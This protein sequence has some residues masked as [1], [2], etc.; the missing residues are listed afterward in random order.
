MYIVH[1]A[2][3]IHSANVTSA[4]SLGSIRTIFRTARPCPPPVHPEFTSFLFAAQP[5]NP[6]FQS[7]VQKAGD[8]GQC[9][10]DAKP[11]LTGRLWNRV[12]AAPVAAA[13]RAREPCTGLHGA[14]AAFR[15]AAR[16]SAGRARRRLRLP[17]TEA[18]RMRSAASP[19]PCPLRGRARPAPP[20]LRSP[21]PPAAPAPRSRVL[22]RGR[23]P[24]P[25]PPPPPAPPPSRRAAR[26]SSGRPPSVPAAPWGAGR[27]LPARPRGQ[28]ARPG[29][30]GSGM[31]R[32]A[33][34]LAARERPSLARPGPGAER[35][36]AEGRKAGQRKG[37]EERDGAP[38]PASAALRSPGRPRAPTSRGREHER[39][40]GAGTEGLERLE[41]AAGPTPS[42]GARSRGRAASAGRARLLRA[43][44]AGPGPTR[45]KARKTPL[46]SPARRDA[47]HST[48][49]AWEEARL[50]GWKRRN[51][52]C[53]DNFSRE[54]GPAPSEVL[55]P[56]RSR[57]FVAAFQRREGTRSGSGFPPALPK[58]AL[59]PAL[60]APGIGTGSQSPGDA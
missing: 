34:A 20:P 36:S 56:Q 19:R 13:R 59:V 47:C 4:L 10:G 45:A 54:L 31:G 11:F 1:K 18:R 58:G 29:L 48:P 5:P 14:R 41:D 12:P 53:L 2:K 35:G 60:P 7:S 50:S 40:R 52:L 38:T 24:R 57:S 28:R 43:R 22:T 26:P 9:Q 49:G 51:A 16:L 23:R 37:L 44:G 17:R 46:S 6:L 27:R 25:G 55:L 30:E 21:R 39:A 42:R 8:S 32:S 33:P 3:Y 15:G